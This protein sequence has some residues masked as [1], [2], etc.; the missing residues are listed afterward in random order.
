[1]SWFRPLKYITNVTESEVTIQIMK[2]AQIIYKYH[3]KPD[4][5]LDNDIVKLLNCI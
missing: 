2:I 5:T 1:M 4:E 3:I